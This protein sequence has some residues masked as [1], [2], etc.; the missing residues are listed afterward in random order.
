MKETLCGFEEKIPT[1]N[2]NVYT[3]TTSLYKL[4]NIYLINK[5]FSEKIK[6]PKTVSETRKVPWS[7]KDKQSKTI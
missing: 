7:A 4:K 3:L 1:Q 6:V 2:L 5:L